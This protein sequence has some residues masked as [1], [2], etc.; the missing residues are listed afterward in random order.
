MQ[1]IIDALLFVGSHPGG[2]LTDA[3]ADV[4]QLYGFVQDLSSSGQE[5]LYLTQEGRQ[6]LL[7]NM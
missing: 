6:F 7:E 1:E 2:A 4:L 5:H 3:I